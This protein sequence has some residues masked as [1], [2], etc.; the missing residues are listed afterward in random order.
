MSRTLL[1]VGA[2]AGAL[3]SFARAQE[4]APPDADTLVSDAVEQI[5]I[6]GVRRR[7]VVTGAY[8]PEITYDEED[9]ASLG[10]SSFADILEALAPQ[11]GSGRGRSDGPPAVL[12]NGRRIAGFRE[13][14][15]YPP[16]SIQRVEILSEDAALRFGFRA[17]QRVINFILKDS[18]SAYTVEAEVNAPTEG[19]RS[20]PEIELG[21]LAIN[22]GRRFNLDFRYTTSSELLESE[23]DLRT[24]A[25]SPP[26]SL[27]GNITAPTIGDEIDP[28]LSAL[29]GFTTTV[30]AVPE[31]AAGGAP[32][33]A[34][35]V[36]GANDPRFT[37]L[38]AFR[39]LAPE[40]DEVEFGAGY[41]L[42]GPGD[43][44]ITL[45]GEATLGEQTAL[46]GLPTA[47]LT[48]DPSNPFSDF[49]AP[50]ALHRYVA[51]G[52]ALRQETDSLDAESAITIASAPGVWTWTIIN[53]A[54]FA[55]RDRETETGFE[56][57]AL[58][59]LLDAGDA[60]TNP[61][62]SLSELGTI[63]TQTSETRTLSTGHTALATIPLLAL[64]GGDLAS[65]WKLEY[66]TTDQQTDVRDASGL[67]SA[68]LYRGRATAQASFEA[69][70]YDA[71]GWGSLAANL[72]GAIDDYSDFG[73]LS[74]WGAGL[75][76]SPNDIVR[77][78][79][80]YNREE[81]APSIGQ[82]GDP[83]I[84]T[85]NV[86][87]FDFTT[88][89]TAL[90]DRTTGGA[91]DLRADDRQVVNIGLRLTP[92]GDDDVAL[93]ADYTETRTDDP[94]SG[95][96]TP[97]A[98]IEGAFPSRFTRDINGDLIA[99][100]ARPINFAQSERRQLRWG[101]NLSKRLRASR[102]GRPSGAPPARRGPSA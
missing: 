69:P 38:G 101:I 26:Y 17:D 4:T 15:N 59:T 53:E 10:A 45:S 78:S 61:F 68:S 12:L 30:A 91:D 2:A 90:V 5:V 37:D 27:I 21:R 49:S 3:I 84:V 47:S 74:T 73:T 92:L 34:D 9:V 16:E 83:V 14:R 46:L 87:V 32:V 63:D 88:G 24:E 85:P 67:T 60:T 65:S 44:A 28:A 70:I 100:D 48:L 62:G 98:E 25:P 66:R 11:T 6:Q 54:S 95:F 58:Q 77:L 57:S 55:T 86:R 72:N 18:F 1:L 82:L 96:P 51:G 79:T 40:S 97:T 81:G 35:F 76:W 13:L 56:A 93:I 102:G 42:I 39:T 33:I 75:V 71:E 43:I 50:V 36:A 31:T 8:Q 7:G 20:T 23:R 19:G 94:I 52:G 29:A 22:D 41:N 89:D 64:P 99:L 80:S